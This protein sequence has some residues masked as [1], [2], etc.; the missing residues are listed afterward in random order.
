MIKEVFDRRK[1]KV[2]VRQIKMLLLKEHKILM[3]VKKIAR[4]KRKYGL[5]TKIRRSQAKY[6]LKKKLHEH[7]VVPNIL[8]RKFKVKE[9]NRVYSTDITQFNFSGEKAYL[10]AFKDLATKEIKAFSLTQTPNVV[11]VQK[12]LEVALKS[13][14]LENRPKLLI[15]SDQGI[16]YTHYIYRRT[17]RE[18]GAIQSMSRRGNCLDNAPIE[19]FFGYLKDHIELKGCKTFEELEKMV[20]EEI[21]YYNEER[22][23]WDLNQMPP[24]IYRRHLERSGL[25]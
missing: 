19:S 18:Y 12:A 25:F 23:Q 11:F 20:V 16:H 22:P 5:V 3:N 17:I 4:I 9:A 13:V 24:V 21:R 7:K 10:T 6:H 1:E 2:G 15:H 8:D 14:P